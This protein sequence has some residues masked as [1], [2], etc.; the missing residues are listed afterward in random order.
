MSTVLAATTHSA[1]M[2]LRCPKCAGDMVTYERSGIV[3]DQ[4]RECRGI[5]LDRGEL[6]RLVDAE[7]GGAGWAGP[8]MQAPEPIPLPRV[9]QPW[10]ASGDQR[11]ASSPGT[12]YYSE[13]RGFDDDDDR[14]YRRDAGDW[15]D[16]R[17]WDGRGKP[18]KRRSLIGE[19]L[20]GFGD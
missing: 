20:E 10:S 1:P 11:M 17:R 18:Q 2:A 15:D 19:L 8:Q 4:C 14:P 13:W 5:F 7:S 12:S 16:R 6:E 3:L 9:G